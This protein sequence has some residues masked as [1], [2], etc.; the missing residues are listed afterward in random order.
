MSVKT[1][2]DGNVKVTLLAAKPADKNAIVL[3]ALTD[4]G[5][6]DISCNILSNDFDYGPTGSETVDEKPLCAEGNGQT[7]GLSNYSG[8][9]TVFRYWDPATGLADSTDDFLWEAVKEKGTTLYL[10]VRDSHKK[11]KEAWTAGDEYRYFEVV[12]DD[13]Q[14][15]DRAGFIKY[16]VTLL[17]Q[18]AALD[19]LVVAGP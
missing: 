19:K 16:R 15:G 5:A 12:T 3:T 6:K 8:G 7:P 9:M 4:V 11:S 14:R 10:A 2:A 1:L 17:H 18:D 13:P